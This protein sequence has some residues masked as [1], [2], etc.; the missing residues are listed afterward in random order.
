MRLRSARDRARYTQAVPAKAKPKKPAPRADFG[1]PI[2]G[3]LAKQPPQ[4]R[5]I[6][7]AVRALIDE[8]MPDATAALKWGMPFYARGKT[9][10]V[11]MG[12]HKAHVNLLLPG[13]PGTY[14]DPDALL[15]GDGKTG[16]RLVLKSLD[17]LPRAQVR[18]WLKIAAKR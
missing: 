14:P 4:L 18:A 3:F 2:A 5:A 6:L 16:R 10:L 11:A 1:K 12:A 13:P 9:M 15:E 17:D 8:A 7:D